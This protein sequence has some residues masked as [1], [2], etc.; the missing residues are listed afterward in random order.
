MILGS[1]IVPDPAWKPFSPLFLSFLSSSVLAPSLLSP[2]SL[3]L[4]LVSLLLVLSPE[5]SDAFSA[6]FSS[7]PSS[8]SELKAI[9]SGSSLLVFFSRPALGWMR[10]L[11]KSCGVFFE[12]S[13]EIE[14]EGGGL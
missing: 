7:P 4:E 2:L 8:S 6:S 14:E 13:D 11:R 12:S 5:P 1:Q 3:T 9:H 10:I